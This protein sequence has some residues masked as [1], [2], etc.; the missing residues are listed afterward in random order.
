M[1]TNSRRRTR[2]PLWAALG[3][4]A[5]VPALAEAQ[6]FPNLAIKRERPCCNAEDPV[7]RLYRH[8][9]YGYHPTCWR[10]FPPGWGCPSPEGP[11]TAAAMEEIRRDLERQPREDFG[12]GGR[13]APDLGPYPG[14]DEPGMQGGTGEIEFPPLPDSDRSPFEL[15][16]PGGANPGGRGPA[17]LPR[18]PEGPQAGSAAS[19][20]DALPADTSASLLDPIE[21]DSGLDALAAGSDVGPGDSPTGPPLALLDVGHPDLSLGRPASV[22]PNGGL[23][24]FPASPEPSN[25]DLP[26]MVAAMPAEGMAGPPPAVQ[27]PQRRGLIGGLFQNVGRRRR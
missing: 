3:L 12:G 26:P 27:A 9:Y 7:F 15:D 6:L 18:M 20:L 16:P 8:Q 22:D 5:G 14:E 24:P 11:Q 19:P 4:I 17:P 25:P 1:L 13:T 2:W 21:T 10:R 23:M